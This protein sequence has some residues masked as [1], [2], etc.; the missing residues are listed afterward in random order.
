MF[1]AAMLHAW[2]EHGQGL[3][4]AIR[5]AGVPASVPIVWSDARDGALTGFRFKVGQADLDQRE[6][7]A[8]MQF[9][10]I[11]DRLRQARLASGVRERALAIF[12]H[13]AEAESEVHG[14]PVPEV[15]FHE[16][17]AIDSIADIV[18]AAFLIE[19]VGPATW[20]CGSL[21]M[22]SGEV[23]TA[24]GRLPVPAPA[25]ALLLKGFLVHTD[26]IPGE[27]VTPTGAAI[28]RHLAP[29]Q[30]LPRGPSR[31]ARVGAGFGTKRFPDRPN[32]LRLL[33]SEEVTAGLAGP[34]GQGEDVA[35]VVFEVD[36][37]S[38]EDL[39]V[40]LDRLRALT[41][42]LTV[43]HTPALAK[44]GRL[45]S[46]IELLCRPDALQSAIAACFVETTTIGLRWTLE[47]REV[48][49]RE[50]VAVPAGD[51][52][53]VRVKM[54]ERPGGARTAKPDIEDLKDAAGGQPGRA[55][56]GKD[57]VERALDGRKARP[58]RQQKG[59]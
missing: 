46:R 35:V 13:L 6:T 11:R 39:A 14:V 43:M 12:T 36:D 44:K 56:R 10:A 2:P 57:A 22:G 55:R 3:L 51:S 30:G 53:K 37:Q 45:A 48:L 24:H 18:G 52:R 19:A 28:L 29:A 9:S 20:S 34:L 50:E 33:A 25:T 58:E 16:V 47:R 21:P 54:V 40:G 59:R 8:H 4:D 15:A 7:H 23:M 26:A 5:A 32:C 27:R 49:A 31:L 38:P 1:C 41:G 42:V 17:G